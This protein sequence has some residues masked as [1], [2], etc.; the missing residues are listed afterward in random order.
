MIVWAMMAEYEQD[1]IAVQDI[2][3]SSAARKY[4]I[5][6]QVHGLRQVLSP[7]Q[8]TAVQLQCVSD[9]APIGVQLNFTNNTDEESVDI[10]DA[11]GGQ[12]CLGLSINWPNPNEA[13]VG[14][15]SFQGCPKCGN[16]SIGATLMFAA[17]LIAKD[18]EMANLILHDSSYLTCKT[19]NQSGTSLAVFRLLTKGKTWYESMGYYFDDNSDKADDINECYADDLNR[20]ALVAAGKLA[21]PNEWKEKMPDKVQEAEQTSNGQNLTVGMFLNWLWNK[22]CYDYEDRVR[23][24]RIPGYGNLSLVYVGE[25]RRDNNEPYIWGTIRSGM[26]KQVV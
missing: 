20:T 25:K 19:N 8:P 7:S 9:G 10:L 14:L 18:F 3:S 12:S 17:N 26:R 2:A 21:V 4:I 13:Y 22:Y 6:S 24:L 5:G 23:P 15:D 1:L 16:K 11:A